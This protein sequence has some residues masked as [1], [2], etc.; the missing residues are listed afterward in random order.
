MIGYF[1]IQ[2]EDQHSQPWGNHQRGQ[3]ETDPQ[4]RQT[5]AKGRFSYLDWYFSLLCS[6]FFLCTWTFQSWKSKYILFVHML[7]STKAGTE[8]PSLSVTQQNIALYSWIF[9][10]R[11]EK[12]HITLPR[13]IEDAKNLGRVLSRYKD[14]YYLQVLGGYFITY[15]LYPFAWIKHEGGWKNPSPK[16]K[17]C[18]SSVNVV[19]LWRFDS[20]YFS[21]RKNSLQSFAIPGSIFLSILSGFLF[22]FPLALCMVCLVSKAET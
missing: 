21:W 20:Q 12:Q 17:T 3:T 18:P 6:A 13:N 5:A 1:Q 8:R 2:M 7:H 15:I 22:P 16:V 19:W 11:S 10:V 14:K 9:F 4:W